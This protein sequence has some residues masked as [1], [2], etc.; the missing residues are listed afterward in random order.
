MN[1]CL[2]YSRKSAF[3]LIEMSIV[4]VII[5]LIIGGILAGRD[6]IDA[7]AQHAQIAQINNYNTAVLAFENK[8]GYLPGDIPDPVAS[9]F[10]FQA[11][12]T[13][14]GEGD[15]NGILEGNCAGNLNNGFDQGCGELPFFWVDISKAGL[16]DRSIVTSG[17]YPSMTASTSVNG[18]ALVATWLPTSKLSRN[19]FIYVFSYGGANYFGISV[20]DGIGWTLWT[21]GSPGVTVQQAFN[22]DSK[23]DDGLPQSGSVTACY[24]N[25]SLEDHRAI[26]SAGGGNEGSPVTAYGHNCDPTTAATAYANTNCYDN[27]N[28][29]GTEKYSLSQNAN[30]QNCALAFRFP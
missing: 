10:G 29:A 1:K 20:V 11:R 12:G 30:I 24:V 8:Y 17:G 9:N 5:G 25:S 26:W 19:T 23:I 27:N 3:T 2:A 28:V 22:I 6:L 7:A 13:A 16:I 4:L 15:G 14:A 21:A 18:S